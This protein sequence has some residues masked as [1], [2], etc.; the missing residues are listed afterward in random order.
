M[1]LAR[2]LPLWGWLQRNPLLCLCAGLA[3]WG[4]YERHQHVGWRD[5][6]K[7]LE[8][9]SREAEVAQA[10]V[11][12]EPARISAAIAEKSDAQAPAYHADV[13]RAADAARLRP[14]AGCAVHPDLRRADPPTPVDDRPAAAS[15]V[16]S[17]PQA[18]D[19]LLVAAA[20]RAALC[21]ADA[22]ALIAAGLAIKGDN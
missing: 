14:E 1:M 12:H 6:A 16:V 2:L 3:L 20:G 13:R 9:A 7:R 22:Q 18:D 8:Q 4:A 15:G 10:I 19:D 5:Y 21:V 17:R 11:N